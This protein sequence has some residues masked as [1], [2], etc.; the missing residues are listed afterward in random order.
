MRGTLPN[1]D[2]PRIPPSGVLSQSASSAGPTSLLVAE[3]GSEFSYFLRSLILV[4]ENTDFVLG[5]R[6]V[7]GPGHPEEYGWFRNAFSAG[8][9]FGGQIYLNLV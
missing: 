4:G 7:L 5:V 6:G 9:L 2:Q 8:N 1:T 3:P